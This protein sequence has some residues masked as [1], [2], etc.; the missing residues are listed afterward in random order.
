MPFRLALMTAVA[1]MLVHAQFLRGVSLAGAEFSDDHIPGILNVDFAYN[2]EA[3]FR[4]FSGKGLNLIR[5]P[6]RW[7]RLQPILFGP[8]EESNLSALKT[9]IGWAASYGAKVIIDVHNYG[10][11]KIRDGPDSKEY[12]LDN[13]EAGTVKVPGAALADLWLRLSREFKSAPA[14]YA[15][16]LMNEPHDMGAG[17]WKAISQMALSAIRGNNDAKLV[18]VAGDGWSSAER[19]PAVH[20][21]KG[22]IN[23]PAGSFAYE[24]HLYFDSGNSGTYSR[25]Y[26]E[27]LAANPNLPSIGR[28]R[29]APFADWCRANQARCFLGEYGAPGDSRWLAVLDDF[30]TALDEA[31]FDGTYWAGGEWWGNYPLSVQPGNG[32]DRPQMAV[33]LAHASRG[34]LSAVSAA[35][36][37]GTAVAPGSLAAAMGTNLA[38][39]A[40]R[41]ADMPWPE[42]LGGVQVE[43]A[44]SKGLKVMAP[45]L[46]VSP[47]QVN[48]LVPESLDL[49]R[50]QVVLRRD[51]RAVAGGPVDLARVA[52]ALFSANGDGQGIAAAQVLRLKE[53]GELSYELVARFDAAQKRFVPAPVAFAPGDRLFLILYGTGFRRIATSTLASLRIGTTAV[54]LTYAGPHP[55]I[56]GLDQL[57]AELPRSL[58]GSGENRITLTVEGL[59]ANTVVVVFQ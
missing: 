37:K 10:R 18:F 20:G 28:T 9:N 42:T 32:V 25:S 16:G 1:A 30:L 47:G 29:L 33:L 2:S 44:G 5:I 24:A 12:I 56:P 13:V 23:D 6:V 15:Y 22:W 50:A 55:E 11:Y 57:N 43:I 14:V 31:G 35:S 40:L 53:T 8:L 3:S 26:E 51:G 19:W 52:P 45:L 58:A 7:E 4:Y 17:D 59:A 54:P 38:P 27:E 48:F 41:A 39:A 49:G 46:A 21:P 34:A 36:Y